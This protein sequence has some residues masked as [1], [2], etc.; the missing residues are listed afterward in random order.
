MSEGEF[1]KTALKI[2][3]QLSDLRAQIERE[4]Q[5]WFSPNCRQIVKRSCASL[6]QAETKL[7]KIPY[8]VEHGAKK[9]A[10]KMIRQTRELYLTAKNSWRKAVTKEEEFRLQVTQDVMEV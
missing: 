10:A 4:T 7:S 6:L 5:P 3:T 1:E 9:K 8:L 2:R